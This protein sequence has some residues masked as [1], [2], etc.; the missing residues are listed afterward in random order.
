MPNHWFNQETFKPPEGELVLCV[1]VDK[2]GNRSMCFGRWFYPWVIDHTPRRIRIG[3]LRF[4]LANETDSFLLLARSAPFTK[5]MMS[6]M[7]LLAVRHPSSCAC[8]SESV[9]RIFFFLS[10]LKNK[11]KKKPEQSVFTNTSSAPSQSAAT[12]P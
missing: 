4:M 3:T 11:S 2:K 7:L 6:R 5:R 1:K 12:E 10:E 8:F 9:F